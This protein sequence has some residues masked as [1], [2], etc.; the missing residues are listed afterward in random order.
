MGP[1][2]DNRA[3]IFC[4]VLARERFENIGIDPSANP[5]KMKRVVKLQTSVSFRIT[6]LM[7]N[8][9]KSRKKVGQGDG[10]NRRGRTREDP[11]FACV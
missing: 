11:E 5:I 8:Q 6:R 2:F 3:N 9:I 7:N 4:L 1:F 10:E